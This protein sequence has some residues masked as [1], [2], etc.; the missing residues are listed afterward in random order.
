M[1]SS[2]PTIRPLGQPGDLGWVVLAHGERHHSFG[3][4]LVGQS[5]VLELRAEPQNQRR[6]SLTAPSSST[7][8]VTASAA[9]LTSWG[10]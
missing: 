5:W 1:T 2:T 10:A 8:S 4:D 3:H 6:S 9:S 7:R